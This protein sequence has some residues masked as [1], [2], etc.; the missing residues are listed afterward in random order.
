[1]ALSVDTWLLSKKYN[2]SKFLRRGGFRQISLKFYFSS[3]NTGEAKI[4]RFIFR[5]TMSARPVKC[6][7]SMRWGDHVGKHAHASVSTTCNML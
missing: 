5:N 1:M 2:L 3:H 6:G 4:I 7:R